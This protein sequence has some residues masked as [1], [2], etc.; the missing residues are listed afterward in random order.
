MFGDP[1]Q[2]AGPEFL[3]VVKREDVIRPASALQ[4]FM[5]ATRLP[6]DRPALAQE[7]GELSW[8][9]TG[10]RSDREYLTHLGH[11]LAMLD[12]VS[13][14]AQRN[15]L[16]TIDRFGPRSTVCEHAG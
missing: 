16:G 13:K 2:H 7:R 3:V 6:F 14:D 5:R 1:S 10:S 11:R 8:R 12:S 4:H 9:A 15:G